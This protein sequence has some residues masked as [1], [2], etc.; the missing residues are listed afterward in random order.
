MAGK[1]HR[2]PFPNKASWRA[3]QRLQLVHADI[4]G[5]IKPESNSNK[6]YFITFI[7]DFS[8][9]TWV[10]FLCE[11]S[12]A[13]ETFKKFKALVGNECGESIGCL[14]TDRGGSLLPLILIISVVLME[15]KGNSQ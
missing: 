1:Q 4:S 10:Y 5:P 11:K 3:S 12:A 7:D 6:R 13:F 8:R 2:D 15:L 9:K 14:R